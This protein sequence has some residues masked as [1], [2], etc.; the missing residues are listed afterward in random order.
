M[1]VIEDDNLVALTTNVD[2]PPIKSQVQIL[3]K[4]VAHFLKHNFG[5]STDYSFKSNEYAGLKLKKPAPPLTA[6]P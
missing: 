5:R 2:L 3:D 4:E 1:R 6:L